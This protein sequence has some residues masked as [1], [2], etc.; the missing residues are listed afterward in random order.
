MKLSLSNLFYPVSTYNYNLDFTEC[1]NDFI[2]NDIYNDCLP[3]PE[4]YPSIDYSLMPCDFIDD[5]KKEL[6]DQVNCDIKASDKIQKAFKK[7]GLK[8]IGTSFWSPREYNFHSDSIDIEFEVT[9]DKREQL[10]KEIEYYI[11]NIRQKS[12][13]GYISFEPDSFDDVDTDDH[14]YFWAVCKQAGIIDDL[15]EILE[16]MVENAYE[17]YTRLFYDQLFNWLDTLPEY[18]E[19]IKDQK[20]KEFN[21]RHQLKLFNS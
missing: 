20:Q 9:K 2:T 7:Y 15:T 12:F 4:K 21:E 3:D 11:E 13:D 17:V 5:F 14:C 16:N 18:K 10:K 8:Y 19:F 6:A 1:E